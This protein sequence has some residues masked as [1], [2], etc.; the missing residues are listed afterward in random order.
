[1]RARLRK[2]DELDAS[3]LSTWRRWIRE[4]PSVRTPFLSPAYAQAVASVNSSAR[5]LV[6]ANAGQTSA[7]LPLQRLDS[8]FG[9]LGIYEP[10]GG[11]MTDYF[12]FIAPPSTVIDIGSVLRAAGVG[13]LAYSHLDETQ[14]TFG[15]D[16]GPVRR[17]G[18]RINLEQGVD[19]YWQELERRNRRL[20]RDTER[21]ER[22]LLQE[23]GNLTYEYDSS[24]PD[25]DL[26]ALITLKNQQ[27]V[28][29]GQAAPPLQRYSNRRL[30][31]MLL[32]MNAAECKGHLSVLR[33]GGTLIAA[34][35]GVVCHDALHYWFPGYA[36]PFKA[37]GPGRLLLRFMIGEAGLRGI[38]SLDYG[39]GDAPAK[40]DFANQ[41][42]VY[43]SGAWRANGLVGMAS[44]A[45]LSAY[46][47]TAATAN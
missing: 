15:F 10:I 41:E 46:W 36:L 18:L 8:A 39:E 19:H 16:L 47:R 33:A 3:E 21:L 38:R 12:G 20:L 32:H 42:H 26:D 11:C 37:Y 1:M 34:H 17:V 25:E 28:R 13:A 43:H 27:Y 40:R 31:H 29:T 30:L 6:L 5:V 24:R 9:R 35:F 7:F 14:A 44:R 4:Y 23:V 45:A 22:K 2:V